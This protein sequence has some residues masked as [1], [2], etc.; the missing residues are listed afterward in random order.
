M[1]EQR[2]MHARRVRPGVPRWNAGA[3]HER[4]EHRVERLGVDRR[5][6]VEVD[7]AAPL[8]DERRR[9]EVERGRAPIGAAPR[10][11]KREAGGV[12]RPDRRRVDA[13]DLAP[14]RRAPGSGR[15]RCPTTPHPAACTSSSTVGVPP[16]PTHSRQSGASRSAPAKSSSRSSPRS[17]ATSASPG[18]ARYRVRQPS[19][20][21]RVGDRRDRVP[22]VVLA[23]AERALAVLPRLAPVDRAQADDHAARR[24]RGAA[25]RAARAARARGRGSRSDRP[26]RRARAARRTPRSLRS[27]AGCRS[28]DC[29]AAPTTRRGATSTPTGRARARGARR[30]RRRRAARAAAGARP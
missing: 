2:E 12:A 28:R 15:S 25:R 19:A 4:L 29:S 20:A 14:R 9:G 30:P 11:A 18:S 5:H 6:A 16:V 27:D 1:H 17:R 8:P 10:G 23:V 22:A 7:R 21:R 13:V 3:R 24:G 26:R